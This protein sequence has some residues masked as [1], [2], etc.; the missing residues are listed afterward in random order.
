MNPYELPT[1]ER[2]RA[3]DNE[4]AS[5]SLPGNYDAL[6]RMNKFELKGL[7]A[8]ATDTSRSQWQKDNPA[9]TAYHKRRDAFD[10]RD[11]WQARAGSGILNSLGDPSNKWNNTMNRGPLV[12]ALATGVGAG[13]LSAGTLWLLSKLGVVP[14][15]Y[16]A[17]G[18]IGAAV[19]G[20]AL[21]GYSGHKHRQYQAKQAFYSGASAQQQIL[22]ALSRD[23]TLPFHER[24]RLQQAVMILSDAEAQKLQRLIGT[25]G[26]SAIGA[27]VAKYL[28][29]AGLGGTIIG[30]VMGGAIGSAFSGRNNMSRNAV[31]QRTR[32]GYNV[33]GNTF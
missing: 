13:A 20:T 21:G 1:S 4:R 27:L 12:G 16:V 3:F 15:S 10:Y 17:R 23:Q 22:S 7:P 30:A 19:A 9:L 29:H 31:G 33:F 8:M 6:G 26:G 2:I 11:S 25:V 18:G 28:V 5:V 24:S 14:P 32:A